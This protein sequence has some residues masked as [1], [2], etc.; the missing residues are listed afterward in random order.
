MRQHNFLDEVVP[1]PPF[2]VCAPSPMFWRKLK[3]APGCVCY[4]ACYT[5]TVCASS[6]CS[7]LHL[8]SRHLAPYSRLATFGTLSPHWAHPIRHPAQFV[9][10]KYNQPPAGAAGGSPGRYCPPVLIYLVPCRPCIHIYNNSCSTHLHPISC[11]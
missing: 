11:S 8:F 5:R 2:W 1:R 4:L 10:H 3:F 7:G 6:G 9:V